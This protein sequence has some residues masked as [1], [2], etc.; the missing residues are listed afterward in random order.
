MKLISLLILT[1]LITMAQTP[2]TG[3]PTPSTVPNGKPA[4]NGTAGNP[5]VDANLNSATAPG[6]AEVAVTPD[7]KKE[8]VY[9]ESEGRDPFKVYRDPSV[10]I[11]EKINTET[12]HLDDKTDKV[13]VRNIHTISIP[14][15]VV[16][17][18]VV[19]NKDNPVAAIK[20]L[21]GKTYYMRKNDTIGRHE[22]KIV[23]ITRNTVLIE[24]YREFDGQKNLEKIVLK[25]KKNEQN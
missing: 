2:P 19:Y 4:V 1:S 18:G 5:A 23:E 16:L 8:F 13:L 22:G 21:D 7:L 6:A 11:P 20:V 17:L 3:A 14:A 12:R 25:F 24:Q 10:I 9:N 15:E